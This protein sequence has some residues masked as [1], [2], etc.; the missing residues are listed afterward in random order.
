MRR[1][2]SWR[3]SDWI[4]IGWLVFEPIEMK[5][6]SKDGVEMMEIRSLEREGDV[7]VVKGK[8]MRSMPVTLH[9]R[10]EDLWQAFSLFTW[11]TLLRLPMLLFK[12]FTRSRRA[13]RESQ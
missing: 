10:P 5:L 6:V 2:S 8:I 1:T 13:Q 12:G 9:L 11:A 3:I 7:L 4:S